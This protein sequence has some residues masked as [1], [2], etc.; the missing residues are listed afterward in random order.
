MFREKRILSAMILVLVAGLSSLAGFDQE[1]KK[2]RE[3]PTYNPGKTVY[4]LPVPVEPPQGAGSPSSFMALLSR[5]QDYSAS[6]VSSY[7]R[8]GGPRDNLWIPT[9]GEEV[10]LA[11]L[12]GPGA[13]THIWTTFRGGGRDLV[14]RIY[15]EGSQNPSVEAPIGD[16]FGVA[17]GQDANV[18]SL[19][20]QVSSEGRARNCWWYMPFNTSARV[21][22]SAVPSEEK[23]KTDTISLYFY[24]DYLVY[25]R[26]QKDLNY[27]HARFQETDPAERGRPVKLLE[28]EGSGHF[29]GVV[30]GHRARTPGWFGEGDDIIT[31]D[32]K[33]SFLGTGTE[34]YFC[35][36]WGFRVF[37]DL[38]HGVPVMEGRGV[39]SRLSAYRFHIMDA[40]P[41]R[42]SFKFEIE[43]WP[44]I[45]P[46][47]NTGRDYY[48]SVGFWYQSKIHHPWPRLEK[49]LSNEPWNPA[50]G[51]WHI[52][53]A[54]EAEDLGILGYH[55]RLGETE[56]PTVRLEMPNLSGDRMLVFDSGGDGEFSLLVPA[57]N[58]GTYDLTVYFVRAPDF[59]I[60][61]VLVNGQT[62]GDPVDTF[63][64]TDD[65]T[66][67]IWPP[68]DFTFP[69]VRLKAGIN[70]F[71]FSVRD[72]NKASEG[73]KTGIDC[74]LLS[75]K[76]S[77]IS[78]E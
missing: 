19:P 4:P 32:G 55:S 59:G 1:R 78:G 42:T 14:F 11:D 66:R 5:S 13:I 54:V 50:K 56:R 12:R 15:W 37:S 2:T 46:W 60:V 20:I 47:P 75:E 27:F 22:V 3:L 52:A 76:R 58:D 45:S 25:S 49:L 8:E 35:D 23:P 63:L 30:M 33:V 71:S 67:P 9:T 69:G 16:F 64:R 72:K 65:L 18:T 31:V 44:W 38:Y 39:G 43:H 77:P 26:P 24:I 68:K 28:V 6:R 74:L 48:S 41:F 40:I 34:D 36:A 21:T 17:M 10:T 62:V 73:Y 61:N 29:V 7:N 70:I 57:K 53:G 51:R